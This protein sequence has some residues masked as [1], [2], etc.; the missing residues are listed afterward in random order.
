MKDEDTFVDAAAN[1]AVNTPNFTKII[2]EAARKAVEK[3]KPEELARK[4][5]AKIDNAWEKMA[6]KMLGFDNRWGRE[7][8]IDHC[9]GRHSEMSSMLKAKAQKA[10]DEFLRRAGEAL[11]KAPITPD[12]MAAMKKEYDEVFKYTLKK[13]VDARAQRNAEEFVNAKLAKFIDQYVDPEAEAI[14]ALHQAIKNVKD[15]KVAEMLKESLKE[16]E[17]YT[18]RALDD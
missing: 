14:N 9:N 8:E 6:F 2:E 3:F 18:L 17:S 10:V 13:M 11:D 12:I 7:W 15:P 1:R 16:L 4:V 5:E